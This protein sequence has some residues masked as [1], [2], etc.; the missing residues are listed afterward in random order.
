MGCTYTHQQQHR[1]KHLWHV[2]D[3]SVACET[4]AV[5]T[6]ASTYTQVCLTAG[7]DQGDKNTHTNTVAH[8]VCDLKIQCKDRQDTL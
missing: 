1:K 7:N 2:V 6:A 4:V 5:G 8:Q 3:A